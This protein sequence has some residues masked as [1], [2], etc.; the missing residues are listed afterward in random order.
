MTA[1]KPEAPGSIAPEGPV[2]A[3]NKFYPRKAK[4]PDE[5]KDTSDPWRGDGIQT[6]PQ[7]RVETKGAVPAKEAKELN[8]DQGHANAPHTKP[9]AIKPNGTPEEMRK[10]ESV[11]STTALRKPKSGAQRVYPGLKAE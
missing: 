3:A 9:G 7:G 8:G 6:V 1:A 10:V 4:K 2:A 5:A 11:D